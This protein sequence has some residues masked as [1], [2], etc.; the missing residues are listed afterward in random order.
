MIVVIGQLAGLSVIG[1]A[2]MT[3]V[4]GQL[5][6]LIVMIAVKIAVIIAVIGRVVMIG[7]IRELMLS[8]AQKTSS[9]ARVVVAMAARLIHQRNTPEIA[10]KTRVRRE[11]QLTIAIQSAR[12]VAKS[13]TTDQQL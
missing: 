8:V 7:P 5:A 10:G 13:T 2:V 12:R 11:N 9:V 4:I 1:R 6:G 3:A